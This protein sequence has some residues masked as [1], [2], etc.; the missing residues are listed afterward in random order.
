M[1]RVRSTREDSRAGSAPAAAGIP[2]Q[3]QAK[4]ARFESP[5][6]IRQDGR[7]GLIT[8]PASETDAEELEPE[9]SRRPSSSRGVVIPSDVPVGETMDV[10]DVN[11]SLVELGRQ[12]QVSNQVGRSRE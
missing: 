8:T 7:K 9:K 12:D 11:A 1:T 4:R 2:E 3:R 6:E 5:E 10:E